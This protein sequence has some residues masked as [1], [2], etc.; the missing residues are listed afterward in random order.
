VIRAVLRTPSRRLWLAL[1]VGVLAFAAYA[2]NSVDTA[3]SH[4]NQLRSSPSPDSEL[5]TSPERVVVWFSEEI[6]ASL[7]EVRV[8]DANARQVDNGDSSISPTQPTALIVTLP[9]LD[10]GTYTVVWRNLSTVDGHRVV[11]SFRFSV[12]EPL[13]ASVDVPVESQPLTQS[14][15]DPWFR[16]LTFVGVLTLVGTLL[17]DLLVIMPLLDSRDA[18]ALNGERFHE[19][20]RIMYRTTMAA[21]GLVIVGLVALLF[22][23]AAVTFQVSVFAVFGNPL[24]SVLASDWGRLWMF[25]VIAVLVTGGL[26]LL[27]GRAATPVDE[28]DEEI[29]EQAD[30]YAV[31]DHEAS[32]ESALTDSMVGGLAVAASIAVLV[33]TSLTSH[34]AASPGAVR[35]PAVVTDFIHLLAASAWIGGLSMLAIL[36]II[37]LRRRDDNLDISD[38]LPMLSR[39]SPIALISAGT[40][41]VTG[42]VAGYLQVTIPAATA[43]PYG[44]ALVTKL[45]LLVPLFGF[46]VFNSY[47]VSRKLIGSQFLDLRK[48]ILIEVVIAV[49]VIACVGWLAGLEPARQYAGRN[50]IGVADSVAFS[51]FAE[52][53][54]IDVTLTPGGMGKNVAEVIMTDRRGMPITN[55]TDVRVRLKFLGDDLGEPLI[56]LIDTGNGVWRG[57]DF[58]ITI[59]GVYQAEISIVRPD[60]FDARTSFRFD[61]TPPASLTDA[62]APD[63][64]VT[65]TLLGLELL[66]IG[67]LLSVM[68][69]PALNW[70]IPRTRVMAMPGVVVLVVGVGLLLNTQVLKLGF[71]EETFNPFPLNTESIEKGKAVYMSSCVMCHGEAGHGDGPEAAELN[72]R[73]AELEIHVPLHADSD[74]FAFIRDGIPGT[75]MPAQK[76]TLSDD[77][78]WNLVNFLRTFERS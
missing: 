36:S 14:P 69:T 60:A 11:G 18:P 5:E 21:S 73:P 2:V 43:T 64:V 63:R 77:E 27:A 12:G 8:I 55:A 28:E 22:Q 20:R 53:A 9:A 23:Q 30:E 17:F 66:V 68:A 59:G 71:P 44:W 26:V 67:A 46:A 3:D 75:A 50:G 10:N 42:S 61:A 48:S 40:L 1:L 45:A 25:R 24:S 74:L 33:L 7:S 54:N 29:S 6:E 62:I 57:E 72:P 32:Y 16:W 31:D 15:F 4:A 38:L 47:R 76:G 39:F 13:S 51:D 37:L 19:V 34:N 65:W 58:N 52:G 35:V 70:L 49:L 41:I 56:S 78:M